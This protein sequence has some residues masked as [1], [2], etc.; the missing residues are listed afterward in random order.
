VSDEHT[1]CAQSTDEYLADEVLGRHQREL[2]VEGQYRN[3]VDPG[4]LE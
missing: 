3:H 1:T 4:L 2:L